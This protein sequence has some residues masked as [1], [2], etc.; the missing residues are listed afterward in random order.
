MDEGEE[1]IARRYRSFS[2]MRMHAIPCEGGASRCGSPGSALLPERHAGES[3]S[4][5]LGVKKVLHTEGHTE[6][7]GFCEP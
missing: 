3:E 5:V 7:T 2:L 6:T 1:V 4:N